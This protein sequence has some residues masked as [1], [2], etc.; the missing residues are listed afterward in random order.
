VFAVGA[1]SFRQRRAV[2]HSAE[3]M[4]DLVADV[5]RYRE[6]LP[7]WSEALIR[8]RS[9]DVLRVDQVLGFSGMRIGFASRAIFRRP[10]Y[11]RISAEPGPFRSLEI[12][13]K[14]VDRG[15]MGCNIELEIEFDL[16]SRLLATVLAPVLVRAASDLLLRFE[17][18][19]RQLFD[20]EAL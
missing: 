11:L 4:F 14:F 20:R 2:P 9:A 16:R 5:E 8:E 10:E 15:D 6:F 13:W 1:Y 17:D 12:R 7:G 3:E 18:R 19:A